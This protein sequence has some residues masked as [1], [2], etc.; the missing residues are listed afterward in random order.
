MPVYTSL[1]PRGR[2]GRPSLRLGSL[3]GVR[4][5]ELWA[6][7]EA[8][9]GPVYARSW[10]SDTVLAE[11]GGRTVDAALSQGE[12]VKVVWRAVADHLELPPSRR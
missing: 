9:L 4:L 6:R 8:E 10:A 7:L 5:T 11:L 1:R 2:V 3:R 12:D